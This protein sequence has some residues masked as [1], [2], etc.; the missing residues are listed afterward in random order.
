[1]KEEGEGMFMGDACWSLLP[2]FAASLPASRSAL[3]CRGKGG[4]VF[5]VIDAR[6]SLFCWI[7]KFKY[8]RLVPIFVSMAVIYD[9]PALNAGVR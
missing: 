9:A 1:M 4:G 5:I 2:V 3:T 7:S 8:T 6:D